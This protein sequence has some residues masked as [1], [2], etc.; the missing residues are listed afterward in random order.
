[1]WCLPG[2]FGLFIAVLDGLN[3]KSEKGERKW[4]SDRRNV[5][6]IWAVQKCIGWLKCVER[7]LRSIY[8]PGTEKFLR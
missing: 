2:T 5:I 8:A 1:M 4:W 6:L 3:L 7:A